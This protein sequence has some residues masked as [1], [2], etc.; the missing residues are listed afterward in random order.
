MLWS[1]LFLSCFFIFDGKHSLERYVLLLILLTI[2]LGHKHPE[3]V[4]SAY[5]DIS[6]SIPVRWGAFYWR[7]DQG[8]EGYSRDTGDTS[9]IWETWKGYGI[10]L[11]PGKR[12]LPKFGHGYGIG[13]ENN[14]RIAMTEVLVKKKR[15]CARDLDPPFPDTFCIKSYHR[16]KDRKVLLKKAAYYF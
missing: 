12:D 14:V 8:R 13:K 15:V 6:F 11:P 16:P 4:Q 1:E 7:L 9:M 3:K 2:D 10:W 5:P